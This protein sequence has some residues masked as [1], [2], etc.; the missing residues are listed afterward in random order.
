MRVFGCRD[1]GESV[2]LVH[3][4]ERIGIGFYLLVELVLWVT[5]LEGLNGIDGREF[6][7][8]KCI[9]GIL[10]C[11]VN[12]KMFDGYVVL[13]L[14]LGRSSRWPGRILSRMNIKAV[15]KSSWNFTSG[16]WFQMLFGNFEWIL[17]AW[18]V[19]RHLNQH[20][21]GPPC[22]LVKLYSSNPW[23]AVRASARPPA[24]AL[25]A[26][27]ER[28]RQSSFLLHEL[29]KQL[30]FLLHGQLWI[31]NI[32]RRQAHL[33]YRRNVSCRGRLTLFLLRWPPTF[34]RR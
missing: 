13:Y 14:E 25:L 11:Y 7:L 16:F 23:W 34:N 17:I 32:L 21:L 24:L 27:L 8:A 29:H 2:I 15:L 3:G 26:L 18:R 6:V 28:H 33:R 1:V 22:F 10:V 5:H 9:C 20:V 31:M 30:L 12:M 19:W 4:L